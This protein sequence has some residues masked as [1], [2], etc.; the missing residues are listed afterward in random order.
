MGQ[1][2]AFKTFCYVQLQDKNL[3]V[4]SPQHTLLWYQENPLLFLFFLFLLMLLLLNLSHHLSQLHLLQFLFTAFLLLFFT[5]FNIFK[6]SVIYNCRRE[7]KNWGRKGKND[8]LSLSIAGYQITPK[9]GGI[10]KQPFYNEH[11]QE[12]RKKGN[13]VHYWWECKLVQPLWKTVWRL[14]KKLKIEL[15]YDPA[16]PPLG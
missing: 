15:S 8:L 1:V 7:T 2:P 12:C 13:T 10:K 9:I 4:F 3:I 6:S 16:I 11:W 5:T 14:L